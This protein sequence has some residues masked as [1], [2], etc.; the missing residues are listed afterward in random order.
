MSR[1]LLTQSFIYVYFLV[2][3]SIPLERGRIRFRGYP[4]ISIPWE[5]LTRYKVINACRPTI[6]QSSLRV[7]KKLS[8][9]I[10]FSFFFFFSNN[11]SVIHSI[12]VIRNFPCKLISRNTIFQ[13]G[14]KIWLLGAQLS[15][16]LCYCINVNFIQGNN[17]I[18]GDT[19]YTAHIYRVY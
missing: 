9:E 4:R 12:I 19:C 10:H 16:P 17:V 11:N 7:V 2:S 6:F 1:E 8:N 18:Y 14:K 15:F 3:C 13:S 5:F